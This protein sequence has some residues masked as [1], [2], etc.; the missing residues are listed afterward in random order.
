LRA[1]NNITQHH[2]SVVH[3]LAWECVFWWK[4]FAVNAWRHTS[5]FLHIKCIC[6]N[7]NLFKL[8]RNFHKQKGH[9]IFPAK[10]LTDA[11]SW[12]AW[13]C[14]SLHALTAAVNSSSFSLFNIR[15][16]I[17]YCGPKQICCDILGTNPYTASLRCRLK[18]PEI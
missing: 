14:Q 3:L 16:E 2:D 15:H 11:C 4:I 7:R 5:K 9:S 10:I 13:R 18:A 8:F 12:Y 17:F 6:N 1:D